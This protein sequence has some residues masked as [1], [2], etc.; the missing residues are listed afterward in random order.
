MDRFDCSEKTTDAFGEMA[1][2]MVDPSRFLFI[3]KALVFDEGQM[4][5]QST[6]IADHPFL[7]DHT[8]TEFLYPGVIHGN[9]C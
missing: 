3:D 6:L 4:V 8:S 5:T 7:S 2:I 1:A 9:V